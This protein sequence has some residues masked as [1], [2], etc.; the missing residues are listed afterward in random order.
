MRIA[1]QAYPFV[2]FAS[3]RL[4]HF[5]FAT[6]YV[7]P[8]LFVFLEVLDRLD[9]FIADRTEPILWAITERSVAFDR[10]GPFAIDPPIP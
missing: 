2:C 3:E 4:R 8:V 6:G 7:N 10:R 9:E 1:V 5:L